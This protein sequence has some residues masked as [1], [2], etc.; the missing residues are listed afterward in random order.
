MGCRHST[1]FVRPAD[2]PI[3]PQ[4]PTG[5][6]RTLRPVARWRAIGGGMQEVMPRLTKACA[7]PFPM[8][9]GDTLGQLHERGYRTGCCREPVSSKVPDLKI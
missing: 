3:G 9:R 2:Q 1:V 7:I 6:L 5:I 8:Q 4:T